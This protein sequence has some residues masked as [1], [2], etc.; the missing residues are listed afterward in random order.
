VLLLSAPGVGKSDAV[1]QVA[2]ENHL[3]VRFLLGTQIAPEDVSGVPRIVGERAVFCPPRTL[4]G[5]GEPF[6]LFLDEL[7]ACP[8]EVQKAFYSLLLERRIGEYEL[9]PGTWVVAAG[10]R[11]QDR[12]LVRSLSAALV[13]RLFMVALR[14]D[15]S[16][17]LA[18]AA[19]NG[20]RSEIRGFVNHVPSALDRT[21]PADPVP[22]STPRS[23]AQLS[24]DLDL[25]EA[26]G[27]LSNEERRALAFGRLTAH[28]AALYCALCEEGL[29][30][31][32][33]PAEYIEDP[34][35]LPQTDTG[36]WFLVSRIRAAVQSGE[37]AVPDDEA[38]AAVFRQKVN[39]FLQA[40]PEEYRFALLLDQVSAWTELGAG[41][42]MLQAL[43]EVTGL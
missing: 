13:N 21:V 25:A 1:R 31:M 4:L 29:A 41:E 42:A 20:I 10:N 12:A 30:E 16:E 2:A 3:E 14:V 15:R 32:R 6:C 8:P 26:A 28:D 38:A 24:R 34:E 40:V 7:P 39:A 35:H 37:L 5:H 18:W 23:W 33:Q 9:P 19:A 11:S 22:F 36:M 17:W 43:R 27:R